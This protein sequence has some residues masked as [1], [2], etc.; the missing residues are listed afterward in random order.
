MPSEKIKI[1][2]DRGGTFTD[3]I[4]SYHGKEEIVKLLSVDPSN[5]DDAPLEGI[6]RLLEK[7]TGK[8]IAREDKLDTSL[9]GIARWEN[10]LICRIYSDGHDGRN[11]C[12]VGKEGRTNCPGHHKGI[13][14]SASNRYQTSS[15]STLMEGNQ[16]RPRIFD[17]AI[18]K[19]DVLYETVLEV[20]ERVTLEDYAEDPDPKEIEVPDDSGKSGLVKGLSGEVVRILK[21]PDLKEVESGL[22]KLY[23]DGY[24][25]IAICFM[26]SYTFPSIHCPYTRL[27]SDHEILVGKLAEKTGFTHVSISSSLM[28]MVTSSPDSLLNSSDQNCSSRDECNCRRLSHSRNQEI[29][30]WFQ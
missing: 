12:A 20:D 8:K 13:Q 27:I 17:L 4:G 22:Q 21:K 24:R 30:R 16:S 1:A 29:Y 26:H 7:F 23:D 5:Y 19:P 9:I 28:P 18:H 11:K 6:R 10:K 25:S 15:R 3:C 14:G 2:I